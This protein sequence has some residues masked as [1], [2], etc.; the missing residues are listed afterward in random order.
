MTS[1][2]ILPI[3]IVIIGLFI[4][5]PFVL[6]TIAPNNILNFNRHTGGVSAPQTGGGILSTSD[7]GETWETI[8]TPENTK[9]RFP[10]GIY[11]LA[12]DPRNPENVYLGAQSSGLWKSENG[13][14][15][16]SRVT[17]PARILPTRSDVYRV[18]VSPSNPN[19]LYL[20]IHAG[21]TGFLLK[22]ADG[23]V[24]FQKVYTADT[25]NADIFDI[26][27]DPFDEKHIIITTEQGGILASLDGGAS[28][29]VEHWFDESVVRVTVNPGAPQELYAITASG[30]VAKTA[31]SG[32]HWTTINPQETTSQTAPTPFPPREGIF[33]PLSSSAPFK[34]SAFALDPAHPAQLYAGTDQG[35]LQSIN[36]GDSWTKLDIAL[37]PES[38]P[39]QTIAIHP[40]VTDTLYVGAGSQL[41]ISVDGGIRWSIKTLPD[42]DKIQ[43]IFPHPQDPKRILIIRKN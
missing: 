10:T 19:T 28:W 2:I 42:N 34:L 16:W 13:G 33:R 21:S 30:S 41:Q 26:H 7:G 9:D 43:S 40:R 24:S 37:S 25:S 4:V 1:K 12:F 22:S 39:I 20:S 27:I 36:G 23:G 18:S 29:T 38:L 5:I 14:S 3:L 17:D 8:N 31:D 11:D 32:A 6:N 35:L 15:T